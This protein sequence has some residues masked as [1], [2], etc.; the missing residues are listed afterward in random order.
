MLRSFNESAHIEN[1]AR[2]AKVIPFEYPFLHWTI[3]WSATISIP[4]S[5]NGFSFCSFLFNRCALWES[6]IPRL[7][8]RG[9]GASFHKYTGLFRQV[10]ICVLTNFSYSYPF[11]CIIWSDVIRWCL[12]I[13][14]GYQ[15]Y[16]I[17]NI[18]EFFGK[19]IQLICYFH[20]IPIQ[21]IYVK[22]LPNIIT[23]INLY[24]RQ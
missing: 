10:V 12:Y 21:C 8:K 19:I 14:I 20:T 17:L 23:W 3:V 11:L 5:I 2:S 9:V 24:T 22:V 7:I 13:V 16:S 18:F 6:M 15:F 1:P 4:V